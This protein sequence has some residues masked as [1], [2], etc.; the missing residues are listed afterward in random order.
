MI[1]GFTCGVW[2][3][4]H[5]G[6]CVF[7][8]ECRRRCDH[9]IIGLQTLPYG[10]T[11]KNVPIQTAMERYI[12]LK[13]YADEIIP[14]DT[15]NDLMAMMGFLDISVRFI[16]DEYLPRRN[17]ITGVENMEERDIELVFIRRLHDFSSSDLRERI[18]NDNDAKFSSPIL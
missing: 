16:S 18:I 5:A 4:V 9:L 7:L 14:Y 13:P 11:N 6:H 12:Q 17:K 1:K 8:S 2:D 3:F 15:E 10:R